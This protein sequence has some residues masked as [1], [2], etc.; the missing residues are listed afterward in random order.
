VDQLTLLI[1][2]PIDFLPSFAF[3]YLRLRMAGGWLLTREDGALYFKCR[4]VRPQK[5]QVE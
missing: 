4:V 2:A 1:H 3:S 5:Y